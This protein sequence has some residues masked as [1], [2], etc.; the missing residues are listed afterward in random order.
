MIYRFTAIIIIKNPPG[1]DGYVLRSHCAEQSP[2]RTLVATGLNYV[3][4]GWSTE[5]ARRASLHFHQ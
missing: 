1:N 3:G 5:K 4:E 2:E